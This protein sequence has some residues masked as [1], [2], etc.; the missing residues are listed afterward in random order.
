MADRDLAF[1]NVLSGGRAGK[2]TALIVF[3]IVV[4][5]A[6]LLG[7]AAVSISRSSALV[8]EVQNAKNELA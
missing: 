5:L 7:F 6:L 4:V 3:P 8:S 2:R 1:E